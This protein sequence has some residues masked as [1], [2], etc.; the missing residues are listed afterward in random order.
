MKVFPLWTIKVWP[1]K[2]GVTM[3]WRAHVLTGFLTPDVFI[4]SIFSRR[5]GA[6]NGPF[7]ND[8]AIAKLLLTPILHDKAVTRLV[9]RPR[10]ESLSLIH[11]S[12][13]TRLLSI[14]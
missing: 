7:F 2:S 12:E 9:F 8:L 6:T 4:L 10:L 11:I 3:D 5:C 1:T 13:P 14:S